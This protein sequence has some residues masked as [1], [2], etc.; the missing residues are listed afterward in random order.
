MIRFVTMFVLIRILSVYPQNSVQKK[1]RDLPGSAKKI[2]ITTDKGEVTFEGK[3][4]EK[5]LKKM[6]HPVPIRV[7][8]QPDFD[9]EV[10]NDSADTEEDMFI[11]NDTPCHGKQKFFFHGNG[12]MPSFKEFL[13]D[14]MMSKLK[15]QVEECCKMDSSM[16]TMQKHMFLNLPRFG[17]HAF[18]EMDEF[19]DC[20]DP[21]TA[22]EKKIVIMK[23]D[24]DKTSVET[25]TGAEA[26]KKIK[27]IEAA[28]KEFDNH[29]KGTKKSVIIKKEIKKE[30]KDK[31]EDKDGK[32]ERN[33]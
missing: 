16:K 12:C 33:E 11:F 4:A 1:L 22:K 32:K 8:I 13:N 9:D 28:E 17:G 24:G 5:L 10:G 21:D 27:E 26:E 18:M 14:S 29:E 19:E 30:V 3:D 25:F 2:T 23:R 7:R 15:K 6:K 20:S 31:P